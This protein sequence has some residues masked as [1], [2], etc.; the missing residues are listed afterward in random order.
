[1]V[2]SHELDV[3]ALFQKGYQYRELCAMVLENSRRFAQQ[4]R[5]YSGYSYAVPGQWQG[6]AQTLRVIGDKRG[7]GTTML[8]EEDYTLLERF[9]HMVP[10][11]VKLIHVV[12]NP[13]DNL[14]TRVRQGSDVGHPVDESKIREQ[15]EILFR[16][17]AVNRRLTEDPVHRVF[18]VKH[19]ELVTD[20]AGRLEE[21]CK[22][23]GMEAPKPWMD[24]C[25]S[26]VFD[27]PK[28]TRHLFDYPPELIREITERM[29]EF[30]FLADYR[31]E[32]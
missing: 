1:M 3:L 27:S 7:G 32:D 26:I 29:Q 16:Q 28:R 4:G 2:I 22:F 11:T 10:V 31:F 15:V 14:V 12:R 8:L 23:L 30:P 20:P 25:T 13:F 6:D 17:A 5:S 18:T 24:A 9:C 21:I 19:E